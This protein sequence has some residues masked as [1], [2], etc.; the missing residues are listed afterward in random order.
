MVT[1]NASPPW[2]TRLLNTDDDPED[3]KGKMQ[4]KA[5]LYKWKSAKKH[6]LYI[7]ACWNKFVVRWSRSSAL[8]S[9]FKELGRNKENRKYVTYML[10]NF[11][12]HE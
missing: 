2:Y 4:S 9:S 10:N 5:D 11:L 12:L 1:N 8:S 6:F 3:W 7:N